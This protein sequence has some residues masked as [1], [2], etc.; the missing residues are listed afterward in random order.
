MRASDASL[1]GRTV[2]VIGE[3]RT[4]LVGVVGLRLEWIVGP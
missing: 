1:T 2:L 3:E 4:G